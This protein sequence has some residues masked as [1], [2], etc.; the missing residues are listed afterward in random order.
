MS[1]LTPT[2]DDERR[3]YYRLTAFGQRLAQLLR[4]AQLKN[5]LPGLDTASGIA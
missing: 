2:L 4:V 3:H 1:D 5:L